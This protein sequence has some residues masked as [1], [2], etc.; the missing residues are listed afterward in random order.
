M[1][2]LVYR[3]FVKH[4]V[5]SLS[6]LQLECNNYCS[7]SNYSNL[8]SN[9]ISLV[10]FRLNCSHLTRLRSLLVHV[11]PHPGALE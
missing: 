2:K 7:S 10:S 3:S 1:G 9:V 11:F 5:L 8:F 6:V 4:A